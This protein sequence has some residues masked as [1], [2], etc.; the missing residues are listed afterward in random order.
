MNLYLDNVG[1]ITP[2]PTKDNTDNI[3]HN[4]DNNKD[5]NNSG[6]NEV[7]QAHPR[8]NM[9]STYTLLLGGHTSIQDCIAY[10]KFPHELASGSRVSV[11]ESCKCKWYLSSK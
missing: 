1:I 2:V 11:E 7:S 9:N 8:S 6:G 3:D 4:K 5:N 10:L